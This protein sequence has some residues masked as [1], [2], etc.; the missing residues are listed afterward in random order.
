M[1]IPLMSLHRV[2]HHVFPWGILILTCRKPPP[3]LLHMPMHA[4]KR[5]NLLQTLE[6][7]HDQGAMRPGA[8]VGDVE[9]VAACFG[10]EL[11]AFLDEISE[12]RLA[13]FE[14]AGFVVG[15][16]PISDFFGLRILAISF[17]PAPHAAFCSRLGGRYVPCLRGQWWK[18]W[19]IWW[20]M[21]CG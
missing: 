18:V 13:A 9:V 11:A 20:R 16:D 4:R 10:R 5:N 6:F 21:C 17:S 7:A 3:F 14:L 19:V 12:L 1:R 15:G 8:G 2:P